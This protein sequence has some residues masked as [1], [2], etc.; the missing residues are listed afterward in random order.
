MDQSGNT[1]QLTSGGSPT[2]TGTKLARRLQRNPHRIRRSRHNQSGGCQS[3]QHQRFGKG[4][5]AFANPFKA[6][7][8]VSV[9]RGGLLQQAR[10]RTGHS[11]W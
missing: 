4:G 2:V 9:Q 10:R 1:V 7:Y 5:N 11:R 3:Q 8:T 6:S